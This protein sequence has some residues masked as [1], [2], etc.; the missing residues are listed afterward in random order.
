MITKIFKNTYFLFSVSM[1]DN[2]TSPESYPEYHFAIYLWKYCS[3]IMIALGTVGNIFC[4]VTLLR[5]NLRQQTTVIYLVALSLND[6]IV[7][8]SGL[9]RHWIIQSFDVDVR[10]L[11]EL[12]CKLHLWVVYMS[13]DTSGWILVVVT[14]ER[15]ALVWFPHAS[16]ARC[17]RT[18]AGCI[19]GVL[20][21]TTMLIN[22]HLMFGIGDV[23][24]TESNKTVFEHCYYENDS[25]KRFYLDIWPW[26]DLA[27][28][29]AIPFLL[30]LIGNVIIITSVVKNHQK[31]K[32]TVVPQGT[33]NRM[34]KVNSM[35]ATLIVL[36]TAFLLSTTPISLY[37]AFYKEWSANASHHTIARLTLFWAVANLLMYSNNT[38]NFLLYCVSGGNFRKEIRHLCRRH[39]TSNTEATRATTLVQIQHISTHAMPT[40]E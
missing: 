36:N 14:L 28:F 7:L 29:N 27:K 32:R 25:Y 5:K 26:I 34:K 3:P 24:N 35:T 18:V 15:V 21:G 1:Q 8:Y 11:S 16:K 37:L 30:I 23:T 31:L 9:L 13:L 38:L 10:L 4:I 22:S 40:V 17:N 12:S 2:A 20:I 39:P 33:R 6:L 19:L